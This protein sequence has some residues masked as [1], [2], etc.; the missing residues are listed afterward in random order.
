MPPDIYRRNGPRRLFCDI[1]SC[2]HRR[3]AK[4]NPITKEEQKELLKDAYT[5][6]DRTKLLK[7][8]DSGVDLNMRDDDGCPLW[9]D[10]R[11]AFESHWN[12]GIAEAVQIAETSIKKKQLYEFMDTAINHG[13]DLNIVYYDK[14]DK[15]Y[16]APLFW[17]IYNCYSPE[18]LAYLVKKGMNVNLVIGKSTIL[19]RV[20]S[21]GWFDQFDGNE[22]GDYWTAWAVKY[23][24]AHGAK[25]YDELFMTKV[26]E[27][28]LTP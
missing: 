24:R 12:I 20:D 19:D 18:F 25:Y 23:L 21:E 10:L 11:E 14:R 13:L 15:E 2:N 3:L 26:T 16:Y 27:P 22:S 6:C 5:D 8:I 4:D 7:A 17:M 9:Q 1:I 28:T